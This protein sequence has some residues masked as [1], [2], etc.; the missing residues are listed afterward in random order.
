MEMKIKGF[1]TS[2][3]IF[4]GTNFD[5]SRP[6]TVFSCPSAFLL[7]MRCLARGELV[8]E[9]EDFAEAGLVHSRIEIEL[10]GR[11]YEL[12]STPRS[13]SM[14]ARG[15]SERLAIRLRALCGMQRDLFDIDEVKRQA[16]LLGNPPLSECDITVAAFRSFLESIKSGERC[17]GDTPIYVMNFFE[18]LDEAIDPLLFIEELASLGRQVFVSVTPSYP[19]ERLVHDKVQIISQEREGGRK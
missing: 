5:E 18:R 11:I 15:E 9:R 7:M 10:G 8:P 2:S 3:P 13:H 1:G 14:L 6:I 19:A 12:M 17:K 16:H 4:S